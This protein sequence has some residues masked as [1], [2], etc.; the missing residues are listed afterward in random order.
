M[1]ILKLSFFILLVS[2][3]GVVAAQ[4]NDGKS[5]INQVKQNNKDYIFSDKTATTENEAINQAMA[6]LK[7]KLDEYAEDPSHGPIELIIGLVK[8]VVTITVERGDQYRAFIY[9]KKPDVNKEESIPS[10]NSRGEKEKPIELSL[11]PV[12]KPTPLP[13][14]VSVQKPTSES[15]AVQTPD[16]AKSRGKL[17]ISEIVSEITKIST[18]Q[19]LG[20]ILYEQRERGTVLHYG[21]YTNLSQPEIYYLVACDRKTGKILAVLSPGRVSR[22]NLKNRQTDNIENYN[23]CKIIGFRL[24][25]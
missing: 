20:G 24:A 4:D 15:V 2:I 3:V 13:S 11:E 6:E 12:S 21:E 22:T 19:E 1:N 7:E 18:L 5:R 17:T 10:S 25:K 14:N 16:S 23:N 8:E 9:V